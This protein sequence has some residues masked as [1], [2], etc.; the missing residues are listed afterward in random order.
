M[1]QSETG[2]KIIVN[3]CE[4][5]HRSIR[6]KKTSFETNF[7]MISASKKD[8]R[9]FFFRYMIY[10]MITG[11][12]SGMTD[13]RFKVLGVEKDAQTNANSGEVENKKLG[14]VSVV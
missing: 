8:F 13:S 3:D 1:L 5:L 6:L 9:H 14:I 11:I 4:L 12:F 2:G 7:E 10:F